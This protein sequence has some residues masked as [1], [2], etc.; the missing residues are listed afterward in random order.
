MTNI[1]FSIYLSPEIRFDVHVDSHSK[2]G[3]IKMQLMIK[4]KFPE[5]KHSYFCL[6]EIRNNLDVIGNKIIT[7]R[8]SFFK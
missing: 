2:I 1:I 8:R 5:N 4:M 7:I 3:D 6:C